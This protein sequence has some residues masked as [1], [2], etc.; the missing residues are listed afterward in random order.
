MT[1]RTTI[2]SALTLATAVAAWALPQTATQ[3]AAPAKPARPVV[4]KEAV[5]WPAADIKWKDQEN[6]PGSKTAVLWGEPEKDGYGMLNRWPAGTDVPLH[7]HT[8]DMRGVLLEGTLVITP[9]GGSAQTLTPGGSYAY[10][11]G[12]LKHTTTCKAG[13]DC[14]FFSTSNLRFDTKFP[15]EKKKREPSPAPPKQ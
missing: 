8:F 7:W 12:R 14:V 10:V 5:F 13:A 1:R 6:P 9:E 11:P 4:K 15:E 3:E 2:V